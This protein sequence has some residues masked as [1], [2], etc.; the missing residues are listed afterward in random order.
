MTTDGYYVKR[1]VPNGQ[2]PF[3]AQLWLIGR[4]GRPLTLQPRIQAD[5]RK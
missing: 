4:D 5:A 2:A 1:K 3:N